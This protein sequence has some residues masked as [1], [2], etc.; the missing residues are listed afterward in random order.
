MYR[1]DTLTKWA[2]E[3]V[4]RRGREKHLTP[5]DAATEPGQLRVINRNGTVVPYTDEKIDVAKTKAVLAVDGN[6]AVASS[7][8][9]ERVPELMGQVSAVFR[10]RLPS[11]STFHIEETQDQV[12]LALMCRGEHTRGYCDMPANKRGRST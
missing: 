11:G 4:S 5:T 1:K 10:C 2:G 7:R 12:D 9:R 6:M 3:R 8:I